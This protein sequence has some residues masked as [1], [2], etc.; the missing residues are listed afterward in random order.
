MV[1]TSREEVV[2]SDTALELGFWRRGRRGGIFMGS[3]G[4]SARL[5]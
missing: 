5:L 1:E 3:T 4:V 2:G